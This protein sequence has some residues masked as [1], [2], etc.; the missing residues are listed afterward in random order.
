M[1]VAVGNGDQSRRASC[2]G[3]LNGGSVVAR[4]VSQGI[5]LIGNVLF[6]C[7]SGQKVKD[8]RIRICAADDDGAFSDLDASE[9]VLIDSGA[10]CRMSHIDR[11]RNI[12]IHTVR[13]G[14][15]SSQTDLFLG[16]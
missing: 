9:F 12:R 15:G 8:A 4:R 11:D 1:H 13:A 14:R 16:G 5:N 2:S 10:V 3:Y 7:H 6:R